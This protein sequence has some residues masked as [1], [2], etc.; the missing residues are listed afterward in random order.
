MATVS[1]RY[2]GGYWDIDDRKGWIGL[3][4]DNN[5]YYGL[6][7]RDPDELR[8]LLDILRNEKPVHFDT[9]SRRLKIGWGYTNWEK[10]GEG[11]S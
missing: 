7:V 11:E 9:Q 1:V 6:L 4:L 2:Y 8:L 5:S 10:V 3:H